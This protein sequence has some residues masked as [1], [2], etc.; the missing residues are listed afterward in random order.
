V[1]SDFLE[2]VDVAILALIKLSAAFDTVDHEILLKRLIS[3]TV[4]TALCFIGS[5]HISKTI[6]TSRLQI[7][8]YYQGHLMWYSLKIGPWITTPYNIGLCT[9]D[10]EYRAPR[11]VT[12]SLPWRYTSLL[13]LFTQW[14]G[15]SCSPCLG[16]LRCNSEVNEVKQLPIQSRQDRVNLVC[17]SEAY[18][19]AVSYSDQSQLWDHL[20][21]VFVSRPLCLHLSM[22]THV[23]KMTVGCLAALWQSIRQRNTQSN[24]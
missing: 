15:W 21:V 9:P 22:R 7:V 19:S 24:V 5:K 23:A 12:A 10:K 13:L 8:R 2:A 17:Y 6:N 14:N 16:M 18:F 11:S 20:T 4:S 1:L 3:H